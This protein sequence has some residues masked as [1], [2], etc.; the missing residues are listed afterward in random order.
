[1]ACGVMCERLFNMCFDASGVMIVESKMVVCLCGLC[2]EHAGSQNRD[3]KQGGMM[4]SKWLQNVD[5][6][7]RN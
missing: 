3:G 5:G 6:E 4:V 1:M 2:K 7:E